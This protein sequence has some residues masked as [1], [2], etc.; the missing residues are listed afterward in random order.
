MQIL[1][2]VDTSELSTTDAR[3]A[4]EQ[5]IKIIRERI[6]QFGSWFP[7]IQKIR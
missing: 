2:E 6:D 1:L 7:S 4:V 5:N 3:N